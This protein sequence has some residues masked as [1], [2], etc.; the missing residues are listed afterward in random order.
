[1]GSLRQR[2]VLDTPQLMHSWPVLA[3]VA[4]ELLLDEVL[5]ALG[6]VAES[7]FISEKSLKE[8]KLP[9]PVLEGREAVG[10]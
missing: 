5:E 1:M 3:V 6:E 10:E 7:F 2:G 8:K 9:E 4:D